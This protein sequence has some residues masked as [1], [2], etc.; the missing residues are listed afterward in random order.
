MFCEFDEQDRLW[1]LHSL[2][3]KANCEAQ[4]CLGCILGICGNLCN[5]TSRRAF[6]GAVPVAAVVRPYA[7]EC[8]LE[9]ACLALTIAQ[10]V[11][12][13]KL[14][15]DSGDKQWCLSHMLLSSYWASGSCV[16]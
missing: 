7:Q 6:V 1:F 11:R 13:L 15:Q 14:W 9:T 2:C 3:S 8:K 16:P 12:S 4:A 5:I 10:G